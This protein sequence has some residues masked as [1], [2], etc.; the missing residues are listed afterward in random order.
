MSSQSTTAFEKLVISG[1]AIPVDV[2]RNKTVT[3]PGVAQVV[4]NG[5]M[6]TRKAGGTY[7]TG[8]GLGVTL[9]QPRGGA[10]AGS[11]IVLNP[12]FAATLPPIPY[13]APQTGGL[14]YGTHVTT[15]AG[16][17]ISVE[18]GR[19]APVG[20]PP[21]SS[22]NTLLENSTA[23]VRV[24]GVINSRAVS[25]T[26]RSATVQGFAEVTNTNEI[27]NL[28]LFSGLIQARA[29]KV[30]AHSTKIDGVFKADQRLEFIGLRVAGQAIDAGVGKDTVIDVANLGRV[31]INHQRETTNANL[32]RAIVIKLD[33][34]RAGLPVGAEVEIGVATTWIIN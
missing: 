33:T 32:I 30:T 17:E 13:K 16:S 26:S 21:S 19:S 20:T 34:A 27:A 8:F 3:I 22:F 6:T 18:A 24:P 14:A 10:P 11:R 15:D 29:I 2:E 23:Y 31:T 4:R 25:S 9:L 12:T 28:Y 7:T 1:R 5:S